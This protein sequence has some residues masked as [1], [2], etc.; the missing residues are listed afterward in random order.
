MIPNI[1]HWLLS[2]NPLIRTLSI[3]TGLPHRG[4]L[5]RKKSPACYFT[6]HFL[7]C[8]ITVLFLHSFFQILIKFLPLL[9]MENIACSLPSKSESIK[10]TVI[11]TFEKNKVYTDMTAAIIHTEVTFLNEVSQN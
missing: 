3:A 9:Y 6:S 4:A 2:S 11:L 5:F 10:K 1:T 8:L 7:T